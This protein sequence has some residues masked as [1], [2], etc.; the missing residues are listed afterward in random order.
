MHLKLGIIIFLTIIA[1]CTTAPESETDPGSEVTSEPGYETPPEM[2]TKPSIEYVYPIGLRDLVRNLV[3]SLLDSHAIGN[4]QTL[5]AFGTVKDKTNLH[6]DTQAITQQIRDMLLDSGQVQLIDDNQG[7]DEINLD[8][9]FRARDN[10]RPLT[11]RF[12]KPKAKNYRLLAVIYDTPIKKYDLNEQYYRMTLSL[13]DLTSGELM[14]IEEQ[15]NLKR[16]TNNER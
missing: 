9:T 4:K 13:L 5:I 12:N 7:A 16:T 14:W 6:L 1:G 11:S 10:S 3:N 8:K 2:T 15:E